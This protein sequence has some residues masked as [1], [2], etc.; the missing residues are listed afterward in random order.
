MSITTGGNV[1]ISYSSEDSVVAESIYSELSA[2]GMD[3]WYAPVSTI[4]GA[5]FK[6]DIKQAVK[7]H[8]VFLLIYSQSCNDSV[9]VQRE[10]AYAFEARVPI[11]AV[12]L[13][14]SPMNDELDYCTGSHTWL[15][16]RGH[17]DRSRS[18]LV[19]Q[20]TCVLL[21]NEAVTDS[22]GHVDVDV[23]CRPARDG[24]VRQIKL[25]GDGVT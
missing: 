13:D 24:Q 6:S 23:E 10:C 9:H 3:V 7:T 1:F 12:R 21:G 19:I 15:D 17:S 14:G 18:D 11:L 8:D 16:V 2:V 4:K 25:S 5:R 22:A 20:H